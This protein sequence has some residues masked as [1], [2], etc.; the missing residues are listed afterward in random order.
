MPGI[1]RGVA[2]PA[3]QTLD[4]PGTNGLVVPR[5]DRTGLPPGPR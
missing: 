1:S 4:E 2:P 5:P 3:G